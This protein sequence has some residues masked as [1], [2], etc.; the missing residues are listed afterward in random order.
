MDRNNR[1]LILAVSDGTGA[2][3]EQ[4][5]RAA[6]LQ[7]P[8]VHPLIERRPA[9]RSREHVSAAIYE[10]RDRAAM[11]VHTLVSPELRRHLYMEAVTYQVITVDLMGS[12]L[13]EM[14]RYLESAPQVRPG[15]LYGDERY[16][17]R[18]EAIE[19][20]IHH[21][22]GQGLQDLDSA[23]IVL[24]GISRTSKTP[25]SIFLAYRG[26]CVA[27]V[28]VV[29][30]MPLPPALTQ[31]QAGRIVGLVVSPNSLAITRRARMRQYPALSFAYTDIDHIRRELRYS[32][33]I[34]ATQK[35]PV[36]DV[37]GKAI[38]ETAREVTS[39]IGL[40]DAR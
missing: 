16:T 37:T 12:I 23:D 10:A 3:V 25:L 30:D 35:W 19:Y 13:T 40:T 6:L 7:F 2:T 34:F 15:L 21:D 32:R 17:R 27:N 39:L 22:D 1:H 29:L 9:V 5:T 8:G 24:T 28:P 20:T 31:V 38:E 36:I 33:K 11:V 26:Y 4:V 18:V 14:A